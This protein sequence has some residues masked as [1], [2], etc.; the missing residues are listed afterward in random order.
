MKQ[1]NI[2]NHYNKETELSMPGMSFEDEEKERLEKETIQEKEE[3]KSIFKNIVIP[4]F[5]E[6]NFT[7]DTLL[8]LT[9]GLFFIISLIGAFFGGKIGNVVAVMF[10]LYITICVTTRI[11][12]FPNTRY[13]NI[14]T[15][16]LSNSLRML[17]KSVFPNLIEKFDYIK[18]I[19]FSNII[20]I[21][22]LIIAIIPSCS[23]LAVVS[24]MLA[25]ISYSSSLCNQDFEPI[26]ESVKLLN[27][28]SPIILIVTSIMGSIFYSSDALNLVGYVVWLIIHYIN[29]LIKDYEFKEV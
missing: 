20:Y 6:I 7:R 17:L 4:N 22:T 11:C 28:I 24:L 26:K 2:L 12:E 14:A 5:K 21:A 1:Y 3:F 23:Y 16:N 13:M 18:V 8:Y 27:N 25:L 15:W 9:L 19:S 10:L 29:H